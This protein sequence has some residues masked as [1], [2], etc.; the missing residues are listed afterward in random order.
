MINRK[1]GILIIHHYP[2]KETLKEKF[3]KIWQSIKIK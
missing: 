1:P 2:K 3:K